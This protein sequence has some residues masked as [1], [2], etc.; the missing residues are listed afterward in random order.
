MDKVIRAAELPVNRCLDMPWADF[1]KIV[2]ACWAQS[3]ALAN[4][5][6]Q[7]LARNDVVRTPG[8]TRMPPVPLCPC[9]KCTRPKKRGKDR[10]KPR[11]QGIDLYA[12]LQDSDLRPFWDGATVQA[13]S[14]LRESEARYR[15]LRKQVVWERSALP[16]TFKYPHPLPVHAQ[17]W[18]ARIE[19]GKPVVEVAL[20]GGR[21]SLELRGGPEFG[22]QLALFRQVAGGSAARKQLVIRGQMTSGS[23]GRRT[24]EDRDPGGGAR[25][26]LRIL[27]KLVCEVEAAPRTAD[28]VLTLC[29]DPAA[30]WVAELD[31]RRAW[32][33][34]ADHIKRTHD[35]AKVRG[36]LDAHEDMLDRMAQDS[37]AERRMKMGRL[38]Q[39]REAREKRVRKHRS[40]MRSWMHEITSHLVG[41]AV[42][43]RVGVVQ[44]KDVDR[45]FIERFPWARLKGLLADKLA[46]VGIAIESA[47]GT[48]AESEGAK[49]V[50]VQ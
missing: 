40:R 24:I 28:R 11:T 41:F 23:N 45:G 18:A 36:W 1:C 42:R 22:R 49:F 50:Q 17:A 5:A 26:H 47:S 25:K 4:W 8:M 33:L 39:L 16:P 2:H 43:Q 3:T 13:S 20:P 34:N 29:T 27:V 6:V 21:V 37:K 31:G 12:H 10:G 46:A 44:Y 48:S 9:P 38:G 14:I 35:W 30:F 7:Q 32:V 19:S 15:A